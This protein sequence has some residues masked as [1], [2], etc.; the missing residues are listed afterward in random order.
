MS[1]TMLPDWSASS[2]TPVI[3][4]LN[5]TTRYTGLIEVVIADPPPSITAAIASGSAST[6]PPPFRCVLSCAV[7]VLA[8]L[9]LESVD[10]TIPPC[11]V[12][13]SPECVLRSPATVAADPA[14]S[15]A[16]S[17]APSAVEIADPSA[18]RTAFS[19]GTLLSLPGLPTEVTSA[20][21]G[22]LAASAA[23]LRRRRRAGSVR[24]HV[25]RARDPPRRPC[26]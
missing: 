1:T 8:S 3:V 5:G 9:S 17:A 13:V 21:A 20:D 18:V 7:G 4:Q 14:A 11:A 26:R 22:M 12:V 6:S 10:A 25:A 19:L 24:A 16:A 2:V 15:L 23:A